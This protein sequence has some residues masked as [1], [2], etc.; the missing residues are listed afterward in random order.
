[1]TERKAGSLYRRIYTLIQ[2]I[3]PGHVSS[4]GRIGQRAGCTARTVGFALAALPANNDVPWQRVVN[5][6]GKISPRADGGSNVLQRDL[7]EIEGVC[8]DEKQRIDLNI[9]G[10]VFSEE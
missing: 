4:Y 5:S 7:L 3:P 8:F 9:Y 2:Q 10:W 1:M 6:Q